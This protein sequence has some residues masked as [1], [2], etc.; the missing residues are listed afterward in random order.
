MKIKHFIL[1]AL[2]ATLMPLASCL[3]SDVVDYGEW[4]EKNDAYLKTIDTR[5]YELIVPDWAPQNS[6]YIKWHNDRSLTANNLVPMSNSTVDIKYELEDIDGNKIQNSYGVM[7]GDSVYQS[8]P[9]NNVIGMWIAMTTM[10]VGDSAT[11]IIPYQSGYGAET[12]TDIKPYSNLI[13]RIKIKA[14]KAFE[15]PNN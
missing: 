2:A 6:V 3:K 13:Y 9:N 15:K 14:I 8:Q 10:H 4:R 7:S 11:L 1:P 5:E 12:R